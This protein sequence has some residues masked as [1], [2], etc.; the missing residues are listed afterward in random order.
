MIPQF[1]ARPPQQGDLY[2]A[3]AGH[4]WHPSFLV[5]SP[6]RQSP[7]ILYV[8]SERKVQMLDGPTICTQGLLKCGPLRPMI[9]PC[10]A[11]LMGR[12]LGVILA[13]FLLKLASSVVADRDRFRRRGPM[14]PSVEVPGFFRVH[15]RVT[16]APLTGEFPEYG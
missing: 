11:A 14:L 15:L 4:A 16:A 10:C 2:T 12:S 8:L 7:V 9:L 1:D 6:H 13:A 3:R 5:V